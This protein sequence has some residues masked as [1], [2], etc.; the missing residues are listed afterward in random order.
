MC[1]DIEVSS[2]VHD[3]ARTRI[4]RGV[5]QRT[6]QSSE[7]A[8]EIEGTDSVFMKGRTTRPARN[9]TNC[10]QVTQIPPRLASGDGLLSSHH[11]CTGKTRR[12]RVKFTF[13][14]D[15]GMQLVTAE[16]FRTNSHQLSIK[17]KEVTRV[18]RSEPN[19]H[20]VDSAC[21]WTQITQKVWKRLPNID[22][23]V[24]AEQWLE[25]LMGSRRV[26]FN[27]D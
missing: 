1:I 27:T 16:G 25:Q 23:N 10:T 7:F 15:V 20:D 8:P 11:P 21:L 19:L 3:T 17:S 26:R 6:R 14:K 9:P 12:N 13:V 4:S 5:A 2:P 22:P 18:L 24:T